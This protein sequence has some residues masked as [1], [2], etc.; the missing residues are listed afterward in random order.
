MG[1]S[2]ALALVLTL[3]CS[4]PAWA[5]APAGRLSV[6][7]PGL[8]FARHAAGARHPRHALLSM[9]EQRD[10][11]RA[12]APA[13]AGRSLAPLVPVLAT[14]L[15][16]AVAGAEPP[17]WLEDTRS[18][19]DIGL[20]LFSLLFFLRIPLTWYPQVRWAWST[21]FLPICPHR[22]DLLAP[23][24]SAIRR[25][26]CSDGPEEISAGCRCHVS[27]MSPKRNGEGAG[28]QSAGGN[29][30]SGCY[31]ISLYPPFIRASS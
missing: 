4:A 29:R 11:H 9:Q 15:V 30:V 17:E 1:A 18:S 13:A 2:A 5:F 22:T 7:E 14:M 10:S 26:A 20:A 24:S 19:L 27:R 6:S 8:R 23:F 28:R 16:P 21:C 3:A 25:A 31:P 12:A